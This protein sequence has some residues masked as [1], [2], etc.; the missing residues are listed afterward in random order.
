MSSP[1]ETAS[2]TINRLGKASGFLSDADRKRELG[3]VC[4]VT[5]ETFL[6]GAQE[7]VDQVGHRP[8]LTSKSC[9]GTPLTV[10]H[11]V[12][13]AR[14][15][16]QRF[17]TS[18]RQ[19]LEFLCQNQFLRVDLGVQGWQTSAI[20]GEP[21]QLKH[22]KSV[23]AILSASRRQWR[24]L[25]Q[26]GHA[27]CVVEH[28]VWDRFG[29]Q[30]LERKTRQ[31]HA[32]QE[33][34][35]LP[36]HVTVDVARL[37]EFVVVTPCALHDAQNAFRWAL[38]GT[39]SDAELLRDVY[40]A[41]ESLRNSADVISSHVAGWVTKSLRLHPDRGDTWVDQRRALWNALGIDMETAETLASDLQLCWLDGA[42]CAREG[43]GGDADLCET[44]ST[45]LMSIW[46]FHKFTESR[47]LTVGTSARTVVAALLTGIESLVRAI[48]KDPT[49][50]KFYIRG[51][52]RLA[53]SRKWFLV[54]A[55]I[56]SRVAEGFQAE[57]MEDSRVTRTY[58]A[59]WRS[60]VDEVKWVVDLPVSVWD[61][62]ASVCDRSAGSLADACI[63]G[64]HISFHFL[65][66]RVLL[67][68]S[69]LPWRLARG[70]V[71]ANLRAL[72]AGPCPDE[73]MSKQ[74]WQL[75]SM[76]FPLSQLVASVN[77]LAEAGWTSLPAEQQHGSLSMIHRW[78][79][80]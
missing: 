37:T 59:L 28:Y 41:I 50:S 67:P 26:M 52:G 80:E 51:F 60:A 23:D 76:S 10:V 57:L 64:A 65:W 49:C 75:L 20:L 18:G 40:V 35:M 78:H 30:A 61:T 73:A 36:P 44:I 24:S 66:R 77:L 79:P 14:S 63:A 34:P 69:E 1:V 74:L 17:Q 3:L 11:R 54:R 46:R 68:A 15:S 71:E 55:A 19:G 31:W 56:V 7:L 22:G 8:M 21:T 32:S 58:D 39:C 29:I 43:A 5:K 13:H 12:T 62:L 70:D 42:L 6:R 16:G 47:W 38:M 2:Q 53:T 48:E 72:A 45:C 4:E 33:L 27:G 25:R 9:D